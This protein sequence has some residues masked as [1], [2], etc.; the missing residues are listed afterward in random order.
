MVLNATGAQVNPAVNDSFYVAPMR[1]AASGISTVGYNVATKE[2]TYGGPAYKALLSTVVSSEEETT[3]TCDI[4]GFFSATPTVTA[5][6][7]V[8]GFEQLRAV[9]VTSLSQNSITFC[10]YNSGTQAG[11][12]TFNFIAMGV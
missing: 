1:Y 2:V 12:I 7:I 8:G 10:T 9:Q 5:T 6:V 4:T 11:G 3:T